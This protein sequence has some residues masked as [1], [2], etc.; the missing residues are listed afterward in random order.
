MR[1]IH[2]QPKIIKK[3]PSSCGTAVCGGQFAIAGFGSEGFCGNRYIFSFFFILS[4]LPIYCRFL[5]M[6]KQDVCEGAGFEGS[7]KNLLPI[8]LVV[9]VDF[10]QF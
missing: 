2:K 9:T 8:F 10:F 4:L 6:K 3:V 5:V 7:I 1:D